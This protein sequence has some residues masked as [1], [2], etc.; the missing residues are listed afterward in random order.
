MNTVHGLEL[1]PCCLLL[2]DEKPALPPNGRG[3][4]TY[5]IYIYFGPRWVF[6]AARGPSLVV[7]SGG[8]S[9]LRCPGFSLWWLHLLWST[10]S[11]RMGFSSCGSRA[12]EHRFSSCGTWAYLLHG[13]WDL[14][15][16]GLDPMS[17]CTGRRILNHCATRE[18]WKGPLKQVFTTNRALQVG[19]GENS[20][21]AV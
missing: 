16:R 15:G 11:R 20:F 7:V 5:F 14:P 18:A 3:L 9:L 6:I 8:Y 21:Q 13:M 2:P 1:V 4:L 19:K 17:P 12:L 10:G